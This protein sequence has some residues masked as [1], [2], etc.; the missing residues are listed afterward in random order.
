M[1]LSQFGIHSA[2]SVVLINFQDSAG[3]VVKNQ[4]QNGIGAGISYS[5]LLRALVESF[6]HRAF[7][8]EVDLSCLG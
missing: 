4:T 6:L 2:C 7:F 3:C 1:R 8:P 5:F